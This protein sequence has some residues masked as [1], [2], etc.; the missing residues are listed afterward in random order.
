MRRMIRVVTIPIR[1][2]AAISMHTTTTGLILL[3]IKYLSS[4]WT[5]NWYLLR[6]FPQSIIIITY[7][8]SGLYYIIRL[9][10]ICLHYWMLV[11]STSKI[12]FLLYWR[13]MI[14]SYT[15][16]RNGG[17]A[18]ATA[19][20]DNAADEKS[21]KSIWQLLNIRCTRIIPAISSTGNFFLPKHE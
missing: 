18:V 13:R 20:D 9:F 8:F 10:T 2:T 11:S 3:F 12:K 1:V 14:F 6:T 17:V 7:F 21:D 19:T 4:Q 5:S 16:R 15:R